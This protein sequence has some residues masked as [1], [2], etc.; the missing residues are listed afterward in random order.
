MAYRD[1]LT[2]LEAQ[3]ASI[4]AELASRGE[5]TLELVEALARAEA[6]LREE[7]AMMLSRIRI[8]SPCDEPWADMVGDDQV[9][10][11]G[12]CDK[13]VYNLSQLAADE[14]IELLSETGTLPCMQLH[15]RRDGTLITA[16]CLV[17]QRRRRRAGGVL[18]GA[19]LLAS[20]ALALAVSAT[21]DE[22]YEALIEI[23]PMAGAVMIF[24]EE[25]VPSEGADEAE[26]GWPEPS[27]RVP[28]E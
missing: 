13:P 10:Q 6:R 2:G 4:R 11:C 22:P 25:P 12:R 8:A 14:A 28:R 20:G 5:D 15:R 16:D 23:P 21:A 18:A 3:R 19:A 17:G 26:D 24:A 27:L 1:T 7:R 9:R